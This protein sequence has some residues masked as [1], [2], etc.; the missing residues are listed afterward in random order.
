MTTSDLS[1]TGVDTDL[2]LRA[3]EAAAAVLPATTPL[4]AVVTQPGSDHVTAP[5]AGAAMAELTTEDGA[6]HRVGVL[7]GSDLVAALA[8]SPLGGLDVGAAV[9]PAVDAAA[10]VLGAR[11]SASS[12]TELALVVSDLEGPFTVVPMVGD[13]I[14]AALLVANTLAPS[15]GAPAA[16][17]VSPAARLT[18][19][20]PTD[21]TADVTADVP[22]ADV[23]AA[24]APAEPSPAELLAAEITEPA[25]TFQQRPTVTSRITQPPVA[26]PA[27]PTA[28]MTVVH[29]QFTPETAQM[30]A[31]TAPSAHRGIEMLAG[32]D[33]EVTVELGRTR[34]AV[35]DLLALSPGTVLELDRAADG[36]A[37]LLVNG[38]LIARGEIVV[39]DEDFGLRI[40]EI[41]EDASA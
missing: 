18:A 15:A 4:E 22:A 26:A 35:R 41:V 20:A 12:A 40:T 24:D 9:Q 6:V 38:R 13:G 16:T 19:D 7:V 5:F 33:M 28:P 37:D 30:F 32:V 1:T 23:P 39:V 10:A 14:E 3:G 27:M 31:D 8:N 36:P 11:A 21:A 25:A 2:V 34:M 29:Q 17:T